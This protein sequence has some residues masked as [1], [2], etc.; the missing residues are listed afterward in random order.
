[1][2]D[3]D[4]ALETLIQEK[5]LLETKIEVKKSEMKYYRK[6]SDEELEDWQRYVKDLKAAIARFKGGNGKG[7]RPVKERKGAIASPAKCGNG[8]STWWCF[9]KCEKYQDKSCTLIK[10]RAKKTKE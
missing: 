9:K 8:R 4:Y 5:E 10:F 7:D 2:K 6:A 1:M 3:N